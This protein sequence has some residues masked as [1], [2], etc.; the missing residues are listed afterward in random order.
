MTEH[1]AVLPLTAASVRLREASALVAE[2]TT[3]IGE[4]QADRASRAAWDRDE[5]DALRQLSSAID[6][7]AMACD[8]LSL[9]LRTAATEVRQ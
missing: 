7:I 1:R 9:S 4:D 8:A 2:A 5:G 6:G 3:L